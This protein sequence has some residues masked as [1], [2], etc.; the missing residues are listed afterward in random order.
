MKNDE[1]TL[2]DIMD[3]RLN[4]IYSLSIEADR[5]MNNAEFTNSASLAGCAI[6]KECEKLYIQNEM[7]IDYLKEIY[8]NQLQEKE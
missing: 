8:K 7:I 5:L 6:K 2:E 1:K 3:S 4:Q